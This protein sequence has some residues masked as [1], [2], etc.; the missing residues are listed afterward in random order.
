MGRKLYEWVAPSGGDVVLHWGNESA[1]GRLYFTDDGAVVSVDM[2]GGY[3]QQ[4]ILIP[5]AVLEAMKA[6]AA[7]GQLRTEVFGHTDIGEPDGRCRHCDLPLLRT[8]VL[9]RYADGKEWSSHT[10]LGELPHDVDA[11]VDRLQA[12][13]G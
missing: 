2:D 4:T 9:T 11:V 3:H 12:D 1:H 6:E 10:H 7:G 5:H 13:D 8:R